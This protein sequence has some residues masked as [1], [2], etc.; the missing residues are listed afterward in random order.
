MEVHVRRIAVPAIAVAVLAVPPA[1]QAATKTVDMGV[2]V[3]QQKAFQTRGTDVNDF[4]PH[5]VT[6]HVGDSV[7]FVPTGFHS[8]DIPARHGHP[9]PLLIPGPPVSGSLDA[10]GSPFWFNGQPSIGFNP[11]VAAATGLGK[12][13]TYTGA[14][15]ILSGLP[16]SEH[17]KPMLV[18][19][20]KRGTY[21]YF[22][23]VHPGMKGTVRVLPR[24]RRI[25]SARKDRAALKKQ[26]AKALAVA[27]GITKVT[28]PQNTV[29]VGLA[30]AHHVEYY[31]F[32]PA[33]MTVP[34][35]TRVTF[36]MPVG[37]AEVH[38]ATTGPGNPETDPGSYLG[39]LAGSLNS[40]A[41]D[42]AAVYPSDPPPAAASLTPT[43]HGNGFWNS[44]A[45]DSLAASPLPAANAVTFSAAGTYEFYCLIHPF[46]HGTVVVQ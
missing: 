12:R 23:N 9:L 17:P 27:K 7:R 44:G 3:K 37:S 16:V 41:F 25:P 5:G 33:T 29:A 2:P 26:V 36:N 14:K 21:T 8:V 22:C 43:S 18:K 40:P 1:A 45:M 13:F 24:S 10:A 19:F 6:V 11:A 35:G 28:V 20:R 31:G 39:K 42:P 38:T 32:L 30:G 34:V 46:M 15:A 4:F